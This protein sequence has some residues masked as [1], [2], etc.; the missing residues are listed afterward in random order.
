MGKQ[1]L[2]HVYYLLFDFIEFF[3]FIYFLRINF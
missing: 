1:I 2:I 3:S